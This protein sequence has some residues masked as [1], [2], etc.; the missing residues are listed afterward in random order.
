M[1]HKNSGHLIKRYLSN[2]LLSIGIA[3]ERSNHLRFYSSEAECRNADVGGHRE[4]TTEETSHNEAQTENPSAKSVKT[5]TSR[6][7]KRGARFRDEFLSKI[8]PWEKIPVSFDKFPY[9]IDEDTKSLLMECV[10]SHLKQKKFRKYGGILKHSSNRIQLQSIPG[11]D[12]YRERLV[13]AVARDLQVP[14]LKLDSSL[15]PPYDISQHSSKVVES[16]K[17]SDQDSCDRVKYN[18]EN[19]SIEEVN[20]TLACGHR[21]EVHEVKG[22][23][24]AVIFNVCGLEAKKDEKSTEPTAK[25][26]VTWLDGIHTHTH[27]HI[28]IML[29]KDVKDED[30]DQMHDCFIAME[31]LYEVLESQQPMLVYFPDTFFSNLSEASWNERCNFVCKAT[32]MFD[33]L[34]GRVVLICGRNKTKVGSNEMEK[35]PDSL[36]KYIKRLGDAIISDIHFNGLFS[37]VMHIKPPKDEDL[38][39]FIKQIEEDRTTVISQ[40]NLSVMHQVL[41]A[42]RLLCTDLE[43]ATTTDMIMTRE[44]VK[45][46]V[47]WA[48]NHYLSSCPLPCVKEDLLHIPHER[49]SWLQD[50][51]E[52]YEKRLVSAVVCAGD[53]GVK[54]DDAGALENVKN[55]LNE[56]VILPLRR[57]ELF[58]RGNLKRT[59]NGVLLFGPPGTGK[60]L[61]AKAL[62][63]EAGANFINVTAAAITSM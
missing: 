22:D 46:I 30:D 10:A 6:L 61:M 4:N 8:V 17:E 16:D 29:M 41:K 23:K 27:T 3:S 32:E 31:Q 33:K 12:L 20:R 5:T 25:E 63:T 56:T 55:I 1:A 60:T 47:A 45:K 24:V 40:G 15:L 43:Q 28:H 44:E 19:T 7:S 37:N 52:G 34:L 21:G 35:F 51:A 42:H 36:K 11:T 2:S 9:Y 39:A 13:S 18:G 57:P 49:E 62:A 50:L 54:F 58:S 59:C 26:I 48:T 38:D 53:I 14:L